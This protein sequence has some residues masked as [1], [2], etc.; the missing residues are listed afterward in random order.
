[1]QKVY[2]HAGFIFYKTL[3]SIILF[4]RRQKNLVEEM[5]AICPNLFATRWA[6]MSRVTR[7]MVENRSEIV[8]YLFETE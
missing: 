8:T 1:M 5:Q 6:S 4:L 3:T 7:F 2:K